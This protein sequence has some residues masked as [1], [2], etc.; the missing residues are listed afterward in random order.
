MD[1][2]NAISE[3]L[4]ILSG[5]NFLRSHLSKSDIAFVENLTKSYENNM[6]R[7]YTFESFHSL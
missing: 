3:T 6:N 1:I 5:D 2:F 4:E 7:I